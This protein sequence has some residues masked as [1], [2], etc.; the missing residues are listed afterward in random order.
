MVRT[1]SRR[2][3]HANVKRAA[4]RFLSL[5]FQGRDIRMTT[6]TNTEIM[7]IPSTIELYLKYL[8]R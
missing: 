1:Y 7:G 2:A 8:S 3:R 4:L 5:N 6:P